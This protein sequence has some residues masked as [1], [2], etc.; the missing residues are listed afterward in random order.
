[1]VAQI[2]VALVVQAHQTVIH[3]LVSVHISLQL[4]LVTVVKIL[5]LLFFIQ[6]KSEIWAC[7]LVSL[8]CRFMSSHLAGSTQFDNKLWTDKYQP[9]KATEVR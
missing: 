2:V 9:I 7:F 5:A 6:L 8:N 1:M 3:F 4:L